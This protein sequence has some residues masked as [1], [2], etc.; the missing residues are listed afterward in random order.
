MIWTK[1]QMRVIRWRAAS[2]QIPLGSLECDGPLYEVR[3]VDLVVFQCFVGY[4]RNACHFGG[5]DIRQSP[6]A[7]SDRPSK[8]EIVHACAAFVGRHFL[9]VSC[10]LCSRILLRVRRIENRVANAARHSA[11]YSANGK[12]CSTRP[13]LLILP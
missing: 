11:V 8:S 2:E 9:R 5:G 1:K 4:R 10:D 13:S 12:S 7:M 6:P 3:D